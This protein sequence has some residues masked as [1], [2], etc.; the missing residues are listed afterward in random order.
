M[1]NLLINER[2]A[3]QEIARLKI[4][5]SETEVDGAIGGIM[6]ENRLTQDSGGRASQARKDNRRVSPAGQGGFRTE[7]A[8]QPGGPE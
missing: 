2:L 4:L 7:K 3:A 6:K 8:C 1:L 5:V